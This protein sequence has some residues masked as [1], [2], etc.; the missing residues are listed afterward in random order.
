[1]TAI[2]ESWWRILSRSAMN[3][4]RFDSAFAVEIETVQSDES[5]LSGSEDELA[6]T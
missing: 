1:V 6:K 4:G 5:S 3:L 2:N